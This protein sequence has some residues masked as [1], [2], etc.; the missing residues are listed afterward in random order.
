[1]SLKA[2]LKARDQRQLDAEALS[3]YLDKT[4]NERS[5]TMNG[6]SQSTTTNFLNRKVEDLR[7]VDHEQARRERLRKLELKADELKRESE[8][9]WAREQSF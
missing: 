2:L 8:R 3:D 5:A 6:S 4:V 1:M 9:G 7:G